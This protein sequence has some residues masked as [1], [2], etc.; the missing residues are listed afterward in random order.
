VI[1]RRGENFGAKKRWEKKP[2]GQGGWDFCSSAKR[3]QWAHP[4]LVHW[5]LLVHSRPYMDMTTKMNIT[6]A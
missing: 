5:W 3:L 6:V 2:C 1:G 4:E